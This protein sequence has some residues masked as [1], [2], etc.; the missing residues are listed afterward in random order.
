M[1]AKEMWDHVPE[2][3]KHVADA[4]SVTTLLG[5][6]FNMLPNIAALLTI[7]WT[8]LRIYESATVQRWLGKQGDS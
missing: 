7:L 8:V 5:T 1:S 3:A 6:L 4:L 2:G